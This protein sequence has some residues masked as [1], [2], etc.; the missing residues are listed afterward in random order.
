MSDYLLI[1]SRD[2]FENGCSHYCQLACQLAANGNKVTLFL[3][4]NAVLATRPCQFSGQLKNL[5]DKR[6]E[7]LADEFSLRERGISPSTLVDGV[8]ES[9]LDL[10]I[11]LLAEGRKVLWH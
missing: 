5:A 6:V 1:E 10:V 11:D 2:P 7:I 4:Q 8:S 3:V 9:P